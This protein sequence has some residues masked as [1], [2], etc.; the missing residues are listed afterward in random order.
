[1][2]KIIIMATI[3]FK[4]PKILVDFMFIIIPLI[5]R[6]ILNILIIVLLLI[7]KSKWI[8]SITKKSITKKRAINISKQQR[9]IQD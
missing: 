6:Y 2:N 9:D 5:N 3:V 1:M 4:Q 7:F 8:K